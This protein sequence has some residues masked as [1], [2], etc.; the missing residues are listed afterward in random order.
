MASDYDSDDE[1]SSGSTASGGDDGEVGV[2]LADGE[3]APADGALRSD[4]VLSGDLCAGLVSSPDPRAMHVASDGCVPTSL[5][6]GRALTARHFP[7]GPQREGQAET[8]AYWRTLG[9]ESESEHDAGAAG[10]AAAA[11]TD[12]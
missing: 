5:P 1:C 9:V 11:Q 8:E 7:D 4:G 2:C 6:W 3:V 10:D 12:G